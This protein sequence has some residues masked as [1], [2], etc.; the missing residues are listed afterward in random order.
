[1]LHKLSRTTRKAILFNTRLR[2]KWLGL[3]E[4]WP[5]KPRVMDWLW[6]A[7]MEMIGRIHD[8]AVLELPK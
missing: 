7:R 2:L 5:I 3:I 8:N 4:W 1:M 6:T